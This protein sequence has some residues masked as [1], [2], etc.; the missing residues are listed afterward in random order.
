M[1]RELLTV[2]TDTPDTASGWVS[3][4]VSFIVTVGVIVAAVFGWLG[5]R[6]ARDAKTEA[7]ATRTENT[8]DHGRVAQAILD[9]RDTVRDLADTTNHRFD[10]LGQS[11]GAVREAHIR[12]L[13]HH[14]EHP[15]KEPPR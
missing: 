11:I 2:S 10:E 7:R 6:Q 5:T 13:E 4:A 8:L 9:L 12:H 1:I 14:V 3:I 15:P